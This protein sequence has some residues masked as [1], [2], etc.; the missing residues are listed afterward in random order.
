MAAPGT[1][2][3]DRK[4]GWSQPT[5][6]EFQRFPGHPAQTALSPVLFPNVDLLLPE[7]YETIY[8]LVPRIEWGGSEAGERAYLDVEPLILDKNY[9]YPSVDDL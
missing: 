9:L 2:F 7:H 1:Q 4:Y 5:Y 3:D 8:D 6:T